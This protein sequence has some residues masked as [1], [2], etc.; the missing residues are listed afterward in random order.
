MP[1]H[2]GVRPQSASGHGW[3][4]ALYS[5]AGE[6]GLASRHAMAVNGFREVEWL[7]A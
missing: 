7:S 5:Y 4:R 3:R 6:A 2:A 1:S